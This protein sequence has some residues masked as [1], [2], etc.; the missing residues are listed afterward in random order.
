V[1]VAADRLHLHCGAEQ[2]LQVALSLADLH[3]GG[4]GAQLLHVLEAG[5][6]EVMDPHAAGTAR[7]VPVHASVALFHPVR[8]PG[9]LVEG[10]VGAPVLHV[11]TLGGRVRREQDTQRRD[12]GV[13]RERGLHGFAFV[14]VHATEDQVDGLGVS[15]AF[16]DEKRE[17]SLLRGTVLGEYDHTPVRGDR[18][19]GSSTHAGAASPRRART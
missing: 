5:A 17:K 8:V 7:G 19:P 10:E 2:D 11:D 1:Q 4:R 3:L 9:N 12:D 15:K 16:C 13:G 6:H 18:A 14:R